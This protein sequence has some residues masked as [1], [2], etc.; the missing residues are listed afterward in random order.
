MKAKK[1]LCIALTLFSEFSSKRQEMHSGV[2]GIK[3][4]PVRQCWST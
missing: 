3:K 1:M 4:N 2:F